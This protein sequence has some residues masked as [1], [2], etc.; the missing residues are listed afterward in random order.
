[1]RFQIR[2]G[3]QFDVDEIP[4]EGEMLWDDTTGRLGIYW[5]GEGGKLIWS[6]SSKDGKVFIPKNGFLSGMTN[7]DGFHGN[8]L[9]FDFSVPD[10][11]RIIDRVN[12]Q[13][14]ADFSYSG[15]SGY[16][17][18]DASLVQTTKNL[19][20]N[21]DLSITRSIGASA[22]FTTNP[23]DANQREFLIAPNWHIWSKSDSLGSLSVEFESVDRVTPVGLLPRVLKVRAQGNPTNTGIRMY[24]SDY[25]SVA[26]KTCNLSL[27]VKAPID[28][29]AKLKI[30]SSVNPSLDIQDYPDMDGTWKRVDFP[31]Y[32]PAVSA[33]Y[34]AAD[35]LFEPSRLSAIDETWLIGGVQ[36]STQP[37]PVVFE[38]RHPNLQRQ[39]VSTVYKEGRIFLPED[40]DTRSVPFDGFALTPSKVDI[41]N[42]TDGDVTVSDLDKTGFNVKVTG[43]TNP[44]GTT[45]KYASYFFPAI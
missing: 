30:S 15:F 12:G 4:F 24:F 27:L 31:I 14:I 40:D 13:V 26:G 35:L 11:I 37:S 39:Y 17:N 20:I 19:A 28:A 38:A 3:N 25:D 2:R 7:E 36:F 1:M 42:P 10:S 32:F 43:M 45:L 21:G 16:I 18:Q 6:L 23:L 34:W 41:H 8:R 5:G 33:A 44:N 9:A 29:K 22:N